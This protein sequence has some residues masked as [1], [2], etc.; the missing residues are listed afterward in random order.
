[1]SNTLKEVEYLW[2]VTYTS[3]DDGHRLTAAV[4]TDQKEADKYCRERAFG[5]KQAVVQTSLWKNEWSGK[6]YEV[7]MR[8]VHVDQPLHRKRG[9]EKLT[10]QERNALG[11]SS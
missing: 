11:V 6:F 8:E 5:E 3:R 9:L 4:F 1:M 7:S 2:A 10:E